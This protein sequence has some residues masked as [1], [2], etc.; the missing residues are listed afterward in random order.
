MAIRTVEKTIGDSLFKI[1]TMNN[2]K[3]IPLLARI[4]KV[5]GQSLSAI[6]GGGESAPQDVETLE[7]IKA[8]NAGQPLT[9]EQEIL[10]AKK[11]EKDQQLF[12]DS[13]SK[14]VGFLTTNMDAETVPA[15][16]K[17]LFRESQ[18]V[19][20]NTVI[21][22]N[23]VELGEL[24]HILVFIAQENFGSVFQLGGIKV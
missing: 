21:G 7:A 23:D 18:V 9:Q 19:K 5:F 24:F 8:S 16:I 13:L 14:A 6:F 10:L 2:D 3:R 15:I 22:F 12:S 4:T 17:D 20:D 1:N 11:A